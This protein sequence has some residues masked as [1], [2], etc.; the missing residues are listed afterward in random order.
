MKL[1]ILAFAAALALATNLSAQT[2]T[3]LHSFT[4]SDGGAPWAGL[5]LSG[6]SL[7]GTTAYGGSSSNG[8]VFAVNTDGTRFMILHS[9]S[10]V[11]DGAN[12]YAGLH[13]LSRICG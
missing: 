7:Y 1:K 4:G 13:L 11:S 6:I 10:G 9:F 5:V 2:F 3:T 12:P 8:T